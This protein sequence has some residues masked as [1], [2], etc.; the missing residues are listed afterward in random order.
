MRKFH[1]W[2]AVVVLWVVAVASAIGQETQTIASI[3]GRFSV[4]FPAG[5]VQESTQ[6][7]P[8]EGIDKETVHEMWVNV[9]DGTTPGVVYMVIYE[10]FPPKY[11]KGAPQ[12]LLVERRNLF[13]KG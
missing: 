13:L 7:T 3:V 6:A 5:E 12:D 8:L 9:G 4:D 10:D 11:T 2:F 1:V